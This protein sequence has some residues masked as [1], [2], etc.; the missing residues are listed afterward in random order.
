MRR[1]T[2]FDMSQSHKEWKVGGFVA[3][4]LVL[5]VMLV[6][7]FSKGLSLLRPSYVVR[8]KTT[9][10]GGIKD[11]AAVLLAGATAGAER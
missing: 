2:R 7:N 8:L 4:S 6:L 11:K 10:V 3:I 5:L 9:N 1:N